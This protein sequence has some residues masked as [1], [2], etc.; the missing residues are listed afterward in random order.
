L[1][2]L[3]ASDLVDVEGVYNYNRRTTPEEGTR[4]VRRAA[5]GFGLIETGG[6]DFH[7]DNTHI[8]LWSMTVPVTAIRQLQM[9][10]EENQ[11]LGEHEKLQKH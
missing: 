5:K 1:R 4:E 7:G 3:K 11:S 10:A 2:D 9:A 6:T 8:G